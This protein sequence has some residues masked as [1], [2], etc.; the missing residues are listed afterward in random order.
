M[1]IF[2]ITDKATDLATLVGS[3][4][5]NKHAAGAILERVKALNPQIADAQRLGAG[6]VL[7]LPESADLKPGAGEPAGGEALAALG[8]LLHTG[9]RDVDGRLTRASEALAAEHAAVRDALKA[10]AARRLVESDP[11][12]KEQLAAA[13]ARFK[14]DQKRAAETRE[15]LDKVKK[16]APA[17]LETLQK[18]FGR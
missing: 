17:E 10:A 16:V 3:L 7:I 5:R 2:I 13:E 4:A 9:L 6:T 12:L 18:M 14:A 1:P 8:T 15:Q 11:Q